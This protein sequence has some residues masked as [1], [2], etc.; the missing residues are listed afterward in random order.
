MVTEK[1]MS[2]KTIEMYLDTSVA[3]VMNG[4][5]NSNSTAHLISKVEQ[6]LQDK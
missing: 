3:M 5:I 2:W 1:R 6:L 4:A